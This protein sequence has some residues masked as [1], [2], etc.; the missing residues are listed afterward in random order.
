MEEMCEWLYIFIAREK[1][2]SSF[3]H[4]IFQSEH[5]QIISFSRNYFLLST[6]FISC[7]SSFLISCQKYKWMMS[8]ES[9]LK[10]LVL[11]TSLSSPRKTRDI[12]RALLSKTGP[13]EMRFPSV[14]LQIPTSY[15]VAQQRSFST[16][17]VLKLAL[18]RSGWLELNFFREWNPRL[19]FKIVHQKHL[20]ASKI[21]AKIF[22]KYFVIYNKLHMQN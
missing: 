13:R 17:V 18:A 2:N 6:N 12:A 1:G 16:R 7:Q 10:Y 19:I 14:S 21:K 15:L 9:I 3:F 8:F 22:K 4:F 5:D 11:V 20:C